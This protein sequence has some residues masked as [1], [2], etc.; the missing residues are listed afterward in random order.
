MI[1]FQG[2]GKRDSDNE[3]IK[4]IQKKQPW[5]Q[6]PDPRGIFLVNTSQCSSLVELEGLREQE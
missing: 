5:L 3:I 2:L 4:C 1:H 6:Y